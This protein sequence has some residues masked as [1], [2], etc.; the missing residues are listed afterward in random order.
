MT[1]EE[2]KAHNEAV[3]KKRGSY[4]ARIS[5]KAHAIEQHVAE[6]IATDPKAKVGILSPV[7]M[8]VIERTAPTK[9]KLN[10]LESAFYEV[11]KRRY[12]GFDDKVYPMGLTLKLGDDCR[13]TVDFLCVSHFSYDN[14]GHQ[15]VLT[16]Y[17]VKGFMRDDALVKLKVAAKMFPFIR[18]VLVTRKA[19]VWTEK[20]IR[21][22]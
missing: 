7:G 17:E 20:E 5:G 2:A 15:D 9:S 11:L 18:F 6:T 22:E 3:E 14:G 12:S 16:G 19:G 1:L 8:S 21:S 10:K 4:A 13:Y